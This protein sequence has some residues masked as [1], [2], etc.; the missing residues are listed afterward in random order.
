MAAIFLIIHT[1]NI[2]FDAFYSR[3]TIDAHPLHTI[4]CQIVPSHC[5]PLRTS[6]VKCSWNVVAIMAASS[7]GDRTFV[8]ICKFSFIW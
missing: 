6:T 4:T 5:C 7:I 1:C 2:L 3:F 8:D